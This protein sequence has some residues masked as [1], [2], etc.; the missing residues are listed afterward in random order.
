MELV[1]GETLKG[2]IPVETALNYATQIATALEAAHEKNI[3]H[4]DLKPANIMITPAGVVKVLDFGLALQ[5]RDREGA[6]STVTMS[7][8]RAGMILGTAAYM[9]PEQARGKPVDK[10]ADIWAFGVV[11]YEMLTGRPLFTGETLSDILVSVLSREPDWKRVPVKAHRLLRRCLE[12]DPQRRLRDIGDAIALVEDAPQATAPSQSR[13]G[14]AAWAVAGVLAV[15]LGVV[16][17]RHAAE[18]KAR[19]LRFTVPLPEKTTFEVVNI[20]TTSVPALSPDGRHLA[21]VANGDGRDSLWVRDLDSLAARALPGTDGA[22]DPFWSPDSRVIAFFAGGKLKKIE[23]AGGPALT[24]C[25]TAYNPRGGSWNQDNVIVFASDSFRGLYRVAAAGGTATPLT[26]LDQ[27]V[28]ENSHRFPWF[29]PDGRHFLYLARSG[30]DPGKDAVY[31]GDLESKT[32]RRVAAVSSNAVYVPGYLLFLRGQTLM[33]QPFDAAK[34][35]ITGEAVPIAEQV[36]YIFS[37]RQ[38]EFSASQNGVLA[39]TS[40]VSTATYQL[41]WMDRSGKALGTLGAP[42]GLSRPAI[43]PDG[44]TVAVDR[45]DPGSGL[46]DV[47]LY[48]LMH[49]T[50]SRFTLGPQL[51]DAP[52]WS[53]DGGHIAFRANQAN[54]MP[55]VY[56]RATRGAAQDEALD[57]ALRMPMDWSRDGRYIIEETQPVSS[58]GFDIW[59]L[60]LFGERKPFPYLQTKFNERLPKLSP[61]GEWLAYQSNDS[62]RYEVYVQTFPKPGGKWQ[63]PQ[64]EASARFGAGMGKSCS[65]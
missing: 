41:T 58:T 10:R 35:R 29:L 19:V 60:P 7:P 46:T 4:R 56:Q 15:A 52:V 45:R 55:N 65:T 42:G 34:A 21:F 40:G 22:L 36:D 24:L 27:T 61:N 6:D 57:K 31:V 51:N 18:E 30:T 44:N 62:G 49:G 33:A 37:N 47:W 8:T 12:K 5:N 25:D 2:P 43:S 64:T 28:P 32:R 9:S 38:A 54:G 1:E 48:D 14:W 16:A 11:L 20:L 53:P 50:N 17:Y 3:T 59:V 13:L 26:E 23:V 63:F 39:Y